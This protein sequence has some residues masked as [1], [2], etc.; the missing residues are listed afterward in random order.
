[1]S[2][3]NHVHKHIAAALCILVVLYAAAYFLL[4]PARSIE[5]VVRIL[6]AAKLLG[7]LALPLFVGI[8]VTVHARYSDS[9][10]IQGYK[11]TP[12]ER[13]EFLRTYN[14]NTLEQLA[15]QALSL[16]AFCAV[17]PESLLVSVY[18]QVAAFLLG[19]FMFFVGYQN[20]PMHRLVGFAVG[21]YPSVIA[22]G[23]SCIFSLRAAA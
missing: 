1:M 2:H 15:L 18:S 7:F 10:L 13:L 16:V 21:Y 9:S 6:L 8:A 22:V 17:A 14:T 4:E 19:R 3:K 23:A 20:A 11:S 5:P 12:T